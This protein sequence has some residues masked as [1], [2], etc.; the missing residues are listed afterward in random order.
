MLKFSKII[1]EEKEMIACQKEVVIIFK[2][3][4]A[5]FILEYENQLFS[6]LGIIFEL[7][8]IPN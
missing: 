7:I 4:N 1:L 2:K 5:T 3:L 8:Y 6:F